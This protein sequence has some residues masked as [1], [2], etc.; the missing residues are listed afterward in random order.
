M[1]MMYA[2]VALENTCLERLRKA[3][4]KCSEERAED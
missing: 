1:R 3:K 4:K 2:D